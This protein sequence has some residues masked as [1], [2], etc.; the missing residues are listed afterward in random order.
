MCGRISPEN[1]GRGGVST[2]ERLQ[3]NNAGTPSEDLGKECSATSPLSPP[4]GKP[5]PRGRRA[6]P[7][8]DRGPIHNHLLARAPQLG[9]RH[10][11]RAQVRRTSPLE[12]PGPPLAP[13][14]GGNGPHR[15]GHPIPAPGGIPTSH[16]SSASRATEG[17]RGASP[18]QPSDGGGH[19]PPRSAGRPYAPQFS[20]EASRGLLA[21]GPPRRARCLSQ[22]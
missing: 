8:W 11:R 20:T 1:G 16:H 18:P 19:A 3:E 21:Q 7:A 12:A 2:R 9:G 15:P 10:P 17:G 22:G 4:M 13:V 6:T 5:S 14:P